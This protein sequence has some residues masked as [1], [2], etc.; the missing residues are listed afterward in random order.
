MINQEMSEYVRKQLQEGKEKT[1]IK[2]ELLK[3]GWTEADVSQVLDMPTSSQ[4]PTPP[5]FTSSGMQAL[6]P[7]AV[8]L[9]FI[10]WSFIA[11]IGMIITLVG[12]MMVYPIIPVLILVAVLACI[13]AWAKLTY[14][15]YRYELHE[16][17]FKKELGVIFKQ[18][19]TIP[20]DRIQN[21]DIHRGILDRILGLSSLNIQ[22]AGSNTTSGGFGRGS[23]GR[24]P[25]ISKEISEKLRIE[26]I[27]RSNQSKNRGF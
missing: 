2:S 27:S 24:L 15:F 12:L 11:I 26:L 8:W 5:S 1:E 6:D 14:Y 21:V 4:P 9:F 16:E 7:K 22:T 20:Y 13:F 19:T 18:Y 23:E 17:G 3:T 25:G 10:Y